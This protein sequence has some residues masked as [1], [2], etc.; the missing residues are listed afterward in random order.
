MACSFAPSGFRSGCHSDP[1]RVAVVVVV[2][3]VVA[4]SVDVLLPVAVVLLLVLLLQ[5]VL[6]VLLAVGV[7]VVVSVDVLLSVAVALLLGATG[8]N[9][10]TG[11]EGGSGQIRRITTGTAS[12]TTGKCHCLIAVHCWIPKC[13]RSK[14][15]SKIWGWCSGG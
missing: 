5:P 15:F 6:L 13:E 1:S 12:S 7:V 2:A 11:S 9:S 3:V 8:C 14:M 4:V 10:V